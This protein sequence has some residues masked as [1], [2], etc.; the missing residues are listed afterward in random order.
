MAEGSKMKDTVK[1]SREV[2]VERSRSKQRSN[3][4]S[5]LHSHYTF[6]P[7]I[8]VEKLTMYKKCLQVRPD[9]E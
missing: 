8:V 7:I 3:L 5:S 6:Q 1:R 4:V 9:A 2:I